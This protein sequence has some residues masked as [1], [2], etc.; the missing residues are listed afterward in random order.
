MQLVFSPRNN[1]TTTR[2]G[3]TDDFGQIHFAINDRESWVKITVKSVMIKK[4]S[5]FAFIIQYVRM[6][7]I[8]QRDDNTRSQNSPTPSE[9]NPGGQEQNQKC[10]QDQ[11]EQHQDES[12]NTRSRQNKIEEL[13]ADNCERPSNNHNGRGE[14]NIPSLRR[15]SI[16]RDEKNKKRNPATDDNEHDTRQIPEESVSSVESPKPRH[17]KASSESFENF[18]E[19]DDYEMI[20]TPP[21]AEQSPAAE[22]VDFMRNAWKLPIPELIIS[23]TGGAKFFNISSPRMRNAFQQGLISAVMATGEAFLN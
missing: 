6:P 14:Q 8:A 15:K 9:Y 22:I 3:V 20:S 2:T 16:G 23:V 18:T 5:L 12:A 17:R 10:E 19:D 21:T 1:R 13:A 4:G 11:Q 7:F